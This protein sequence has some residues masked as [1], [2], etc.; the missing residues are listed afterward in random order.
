LLKNVTEEVSQIALADFSPAHSQEDWKDDISEYVLSRGEYGDLETDMA[1][2]AHTGPEGNQQ[3]IAD[4]KIS[5]EINNGGTLN[6]TG[7]GSVWNDQ[8]GNPKGEASV[9]ARWHQKW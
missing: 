2:R 1:I 5:K 3:A 6:F 8:Y 9:E 4:I 7:Q